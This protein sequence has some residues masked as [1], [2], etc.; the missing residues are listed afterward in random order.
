MSKSK[1]ELLNPMI[2]TYLNRFEAAIDGSN[3]SK[4]SSSLDNNCAITQTI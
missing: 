4:T 1:I 2:E 3:A